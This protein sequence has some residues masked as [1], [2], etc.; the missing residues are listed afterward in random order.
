[1]VTPIWLLSLTDPPTKKRKYYFISVF[2]KLFSFG[3]FNISVYC[4]LD[5]DFYK[6]TNANTQTRKHK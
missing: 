3:I 2:Q 1:M 6:E 4:Y 5:N